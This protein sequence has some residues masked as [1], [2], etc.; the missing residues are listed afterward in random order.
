MILAIDTSTDQGSLALLANASVV[1]ELSWSVRGNHSRHLP[2]ALETV[3]QLEGAHLEDVKGIAVA[4]G[5]GSFSGIRVGMSAAKG[6]ALALD[7]PLVGVATLDIL[8]FQGCHV[9]PAVCA[10]IGAG[11]G[12]IFAARYRGSPSRFDLAEPYTITTTK[13]LV[14]A[15]E[16]SEI[17]IGPASGEILEAL[18]DDE[19]ARHACPGAMQ[20]RRAGFLAELGRRHLDA[21]RQ[22]ELDSLEPIYLRKSAAEEKRANQKE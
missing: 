18:G 2:Q 1:A 22:T 12:E 6:L 17:V 21:G 9:S 5:P 11:R 7:V 3:L 16:R 8:G 15:L 10:V 20:L 14:R 4:S 13:D 19:A